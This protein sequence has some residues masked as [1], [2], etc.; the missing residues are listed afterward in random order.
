M[1][2]GNKVFKQHKSGKGYQKIT[3]DDRIN[4]IYDRFVHNL[5][6]KEIQEKSGLNYHS[7]RNIIKQYKYKG[8]TD[9]KDGRASMKV[10]KNSQQQK[11][12]A[13]REQ[14]IKRPPF[15]KVVVS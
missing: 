11:K 1:S 3:H 2:N 15:E 6:D 12:K 13:P 9:K 10:V 4:I 8:R 7:V 5:S 14:Q